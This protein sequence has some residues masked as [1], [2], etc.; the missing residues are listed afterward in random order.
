M[1]IGGFQR[2]SLIDFPGHISAIVFTLGCGFRCPYCHNPELV[3]P[4]RAPAEISPEAVFR[5]LDT[6]A[7]QVDGVV[8]TG[9]EPTLHPDL[10]DMLGKL[11][12]KGLAVKLDTNGSNPGMLSFLLDRGLLDYVAM[13]VKAPLEHYA[14]V[15]RAPVDTESIRESIGLVMHSGL[16]HEFRTTYV[17]SLLSIEEMLD[18]VPLLR[19]CAR[20]VLQRFQPTKAL[21]ASLLDR[22][23]TGEAALS[24]VQKLMEA[25]GIPASIR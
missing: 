5:F 18:I 12:G 14:R 24:H 3:I 17:D 25:A 9:G 15:V 20:Y 13:D 21:D 19:G 23:P 22:G 6:R 4:A 7:G 2:F 8:I 11:K 10:P 1:R 16:N